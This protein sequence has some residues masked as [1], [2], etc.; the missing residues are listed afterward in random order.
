MLHKVN[1]ESHQD[2]AFLSSVAVNKPLP[3][4]LVLD[5]PYLAQHSFSSDCNPWLPFRFLGSVLPAIP[6]AK[7]WTAIV[8]LTTMGSQLV[9]ACFLVDVR[10]E[11]LT[12]SHRIMTRVKQ[13]QA[14]SSC[15]DELPHAILASGSLTQFQ[16]SVSSAF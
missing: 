2:P 16:G 1:P 7:E 13:K 6:D 5:V 4:P 12:D 9:R 8:G 3:L 11:A 10:V 15:N 14:R